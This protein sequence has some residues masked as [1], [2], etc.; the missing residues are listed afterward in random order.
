[1][2][3]K[4]RKLTMECAQKPLK[5]A[6]SGKSGCGNTTVSRLVAEKL[7]YR[8]INFTFRNIA[9]EHNVTLE[10]ILNRAS[11][12]DY[13]DREVDMRQIDLANGSAGG[14][15]L[16]SRLAIWMLDCAD[17]KIYLKVD[18]GIRVHRIQN[19]EGGDIKQ[20]RE[21]T[22][23][24]DSEDS[25]R[26]KRIYDIDN[27]DYFFADIIINAGKFN[28]EQIANMIVNVVEPIAKLC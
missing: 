26:Y 25:M 13:W 28:A 1:M 6:I 2:A 10:E 18:E 8:F 14:C 12:D 11:K 23:E 9:Q 4:C 3:E 24:R 21:F 5:I 19:R 22:R 27:D 16:G 15:V 20:V 7:G 17:V